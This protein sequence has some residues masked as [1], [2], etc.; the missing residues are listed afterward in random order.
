[1]NLLL[2]TDWITSCVTSV[3][4]G[5]IQW[6]RLWVII[7]VII[8]IDYPSEVSVDLYLNNTNIIKVILMYTLLIILVRYYSDINIYCKIRKQ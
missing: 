1:M 7:L 3:D 6:C 8:N 5:A 4:N 2:I